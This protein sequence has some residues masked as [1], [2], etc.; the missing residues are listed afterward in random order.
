M[1][2]LNPFYNGLDLGPGTYKLSNIIKQNIEDGIEEIV[3]IKKCILEGYRFDLYT[4]N[5]ALRQY[6][7]YYRHNSVLLEKNKLIN[8]PPDVRPQRIIV[9][10]TIL[11]YEPKLGTYEF[12]GGNV[13]VM[14]DFVDIDMD[15]LLE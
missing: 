15:F 3:K 13:S 4:Y 8:V 6:I 1:I 10:G 14:D 2:G 9:S 7:S 5:Q 12:K 11:R